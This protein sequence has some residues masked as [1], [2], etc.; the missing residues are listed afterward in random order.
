MPAR[1]R[2]PRKRARTSTTRRPSELFAEE[3]TQDAADVALTTGLLRAF[4]LRFVIRHRLQAQAAGA[5][6]AVHHQRCAADERAERAHQPAAAA[7][8]EYADRLHRNVRI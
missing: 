4:G 5:G 2:T 8:L 7:R 3:R 6:E 1:L